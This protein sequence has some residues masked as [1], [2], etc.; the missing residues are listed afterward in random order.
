MVGR[1]GAR[2][3]LLQ[4]VG[5]HQALPTGRHALAEEEAVIVHVAVDGDHVAGAANVIRRSKTCG[6]PQ[7]T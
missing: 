2:G 6:L 1:G 4:E 7:D 3:D 5:G